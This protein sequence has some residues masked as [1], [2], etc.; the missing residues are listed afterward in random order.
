MT[1]GDGLL[2][3]AGAILGIP[4]VREHLR[5]EPTDCLNRDTVCSNSNEALET[6]ALND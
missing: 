2:S 5:K 3:L 4:V 6:D 1:G